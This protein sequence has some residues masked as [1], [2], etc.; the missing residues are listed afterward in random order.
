MKACPETATLA[1]VD[2]LSG[3]LWVQ[4]LP[5]GGT[6]RFQVAASGLVTFAVGDRTFDSA[7]SVPIQYR[8]AA[9]LITNQI[10]R[11]ALQAATDASS[12]VTFC[13][14]ATWNEGLNY[15]WDVLP[16]FVGVDVW[17]SSKETFL[18]PDAATGVFKRLGLPTL[19]AIEKEA[20]AAHTDFARFDND[21]AFPESAWRS[22]K[23]AGVLLR[24]KSDGHVTVWQS[25]CDES[26]SATRGPSVTELADTYATNERIE[27]TVELLEDDT[28]TPTVASVRDRLIADIAREAYVELFTDGEFIVSLPEFRSVVAQRVQQHQSLSE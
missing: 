18:S 16:A 14:M 20:S 22:G 13:G 17:S 4:E 3:H 8:R 9:Q 2:D 25:E 26:P 21:T 15:E 5:T 12:T 27:R 19:P 7:E 1:S 11:A 24:D 23:A 10:D 6:F 28:A